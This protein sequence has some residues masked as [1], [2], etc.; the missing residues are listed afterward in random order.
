MTTLP[1]TR[2]ADSTGAPIAY[3]VVGDGPVD[4][5]AVH[6]PFF[7]ID[8]MWDEPTLAHFLNRLSSFSRHIWFDP[9][10]RGASQPLPPSE[11]HLAENIVEDM[12][13]VLDDLGCERAAVLALGSGATPL[14]AASHP[15]RTTALV[16]VNSNVRTLHADDYPDGLSPD[17]FEELLSA[18]RREWGTGAAADMIA[19]TM[20]HDARF[21]AWLG[22]AQRLTSTGVDAYWR[23]RGVL[24]ADLRH[25]LP[26]IKV[27]TLALN[28]Q[29][30][31]PASHGRYIA[32][33]IE[34]AR[35]VELE[36][37]DFLFFVGDTGPMLDAIEEFLT[38]ELPSHDVDRVLATVVFT[39]VVGSTEH[40][41]RV[42]DRR[43][44]E[45]LA[46]HDAVV[47]TELDRHRGRQVKSMGDGILATFDGPGRAVRCTA[48]IRDAVRPLGIEIRAGVH[49]GEIE[50]RGDD[51]GG[52][53]VHIAARVSGLAG[54]GEVLASR[55]V[56]DLVVGSGIEFEDRG[57]HELKGV[58]GTW[59]LF[60]VENV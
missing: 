23:A 30:V 51:I 11:A 8:L 37:N 39:D 44:Q 4:V 60:V 53:G 27:S 18:L 36:G 45:L 57:E 5:L 2:Y 3:Q 41:A 1:E 22:R 12:V 10:G 54:A 28:R 40:A 42:G 49:T 24:G 19:P 26:T 34:G 55:T 58:P 33:H 59:R 17:A 35:F 31:F 20:A 32:D 7:P 38:G 43:W 48:A 14:F 29:T 46:T 16:L 9:R 21:R 6:P 47:R 50:L 52:I 15:E 56:V 13:A 25:T